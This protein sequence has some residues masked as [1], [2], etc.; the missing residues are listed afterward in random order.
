[1]PTQPAARSRM[2]DV[3]FALALFCVFTASLLTVILLGADVWRRTADGM[4]QNFALRT[5]LAYVSEK[6]RRSDAV[7]AVY[8]GELDGLPALILEQ[9]VTGSVYRTYIYHHDGALREILAGPDAVVSPESGQSIAG[10]SAFWVEQAAD[11]L[12]LISCADSDGTTFSVFA[13]LRCGWS[14]DL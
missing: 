11:G 7:G 10:I 12:L 3:V 9:D 8:L 2:V 14:G 5:S 13:G 4:Q 1:M 6:I